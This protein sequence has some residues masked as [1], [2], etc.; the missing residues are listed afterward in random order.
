M[1]LVGLNILVTRA[2]V[3]SEGLS[4]LLRDAGATPLLYPCIATELIPL[5][6]Q[7]IRVLKQVQDGY[8]D[9]LIFVSENAATSFITCLNEAHFT[10]PK[11][12]KIA[13]IGNKTALSIQK[14]GYKV[15]LIPSQYSQ[16]ALANLSDLHEQK[17]LIP[18]GSLHDGSLGRQL[19][20]KGALVNE[21]Q[22]YRTVMGKGGVKI[23]PLLSNN[24][25]DFITFCSPSAV[26]NF[27]KRLHL[28]GG[29]LLLVN[30]IGIACIG[31][32]TQKAAFEMGLKVDVVASTHNSTGLVDSLSTFFARETPSQF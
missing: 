15:E 11:N 6:I 29:N 9:W 7:M 3:Q 20:Q 21:I 30:N 17:I 19:S 4:S 5:N 25:L 28:E 12:I 2:T 1:S 27:K 18:K 31:P 8:F 16:H 24:S 23:L 13:T 26:K 22:T 14:A 32:L 10:L